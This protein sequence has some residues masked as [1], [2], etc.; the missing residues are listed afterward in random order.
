MLAW[1]LNMGFAAGTAAV[2]VP[3]LDA[4]A[5]IYAGQERTTIETGQEST[6][7]HTGQ[8]STQVKA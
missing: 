2:V 3:P 1:L 7:V 4:G 6:A 5:I 8:E